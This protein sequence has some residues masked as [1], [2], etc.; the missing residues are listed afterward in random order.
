MR[1]VEFAGP[2]RMKMCIKFM[3]ESLRTAGISPNEP[4]CWSDLKLIFQELS[5][6]PDQYSD[7]FNRPRGSR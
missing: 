2:R 1:R 4:L 3:D 7:Y 6:N 5:N